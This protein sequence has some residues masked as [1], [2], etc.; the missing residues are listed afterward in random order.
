[1]EQGTEPDPAATAPP[2]PHLDPTTLPPWLIDTA[3]KVD[4]ATIGWIAAGYLAGVEVARRSGP[5]A[6]Q[7]VLMGT[8]GSDPLIVLNC[9]LANG[10]SGAH[11][12][13]HTQFWTEP[14][15]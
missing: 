1:M 2:T 4:P 12:A 10:H 15:P 8:V 13:T 11:S 3:M 14:Q 6:A 7:K 5:C 9:Q